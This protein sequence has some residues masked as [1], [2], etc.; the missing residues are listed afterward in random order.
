MIIQTLSI[1]TIINIYSPI[2]TIIT[3][4]TYQKPYFQKSEFKKKSRSQLSQNFLEKPFQAPKIIF[5]SPKLIDQESLSYGH[6]LK[7]KR[8]KYTFLRE[9]T[10]QVLLRGSSPPKKT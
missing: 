2:I 1:I 5:K 4:V 8:L 3:S 7:D 10:L 9:P 6:F